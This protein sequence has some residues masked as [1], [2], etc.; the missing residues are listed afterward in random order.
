[1]VR[2]FDPDTTELNRLQLVWSPDPALTATLGRQRINLDD[3]RFIGSSAW[4]QDEQTFDAARVDTHLGKFDATYIYI[5]HVNRVFAEDLDWGSDSHV[6]TA[7]YSFAEPLRLSAFAYA[8]DFNSPSTAG[9][10]NQ[11]SL[12]WGAR[13]TGK[14]Q[15]GEF[16]F[17]YAAA[18]AQQSDYGSSLLVYDLGF[19]S[20][21]ATLTHG[22]VS[23]RVAHDELEGN[24]TRGFSTPLGS[25]HAFNGWSDAFISNGAKTTVDGLRDANATLTWATGVKWDYLSNLVV[26]AR[27]HNFEAERTGV[28]LGSELDLMATGN[29]TPQLSWLV[30]FAD[31]DGPGAAP[32]PTDRTKIWFGFEWKM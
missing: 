1:M 31:Y 4:R 5:G 21:E 29:V 8:L 17:D 11:S 12:T 28:D 25:L 23:V 20:V 9:V 19:L 16:R 7:S 14:V 13:A 10:R 18:A 6:L 24:G 30:K 22:P 2:I 26:T 3:Q 32:A 15:A 27:Y